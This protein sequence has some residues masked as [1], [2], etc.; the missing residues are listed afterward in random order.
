[1]AVETCLYGK[2]D[3]QYEGC[4]LSTYERNGYHDSDFYAVCWDEEKQ[5]VVDVEYDTTRA[6]GGGY[7]NIDATPE[8]I[9]KAGSIRRSELTIST[10]CR[11]PMKPRRYESAMRWSW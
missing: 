3:V 9:R 8:T 5:A 11:I 1:M 7:A 10:M 2:T 4:V 6:G